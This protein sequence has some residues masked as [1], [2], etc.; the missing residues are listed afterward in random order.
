[1]ER[2]G[3]P[4]CAS[5]GIDELLRLLASA[6]DRLGAEERRELF[7]S[8]L[9]I[10]LP[11]SQ[12]IY[13]KDATPGFDS[14][15][16]STQLNGTQIERI[17]QQVDVM[18]SHMCTLL[19]SIGS[20]RDGAAVVPPSGASDALPGTLTRTDTAIITSPAA[21][22][23][24]HRPALICIARSDSDGYTPLEVVDAIQ[25]RLIDALRRLYG[26]IELVDIRENPEEC[27]RTF[28][29]GLSRFKA[30]KRKA[31]DTDAGT[32]GAR[33]DLK[34]RLLRDSGFD[35]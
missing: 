3:V 17:M 6:G 10:N 33:H 13:E 9:L 18:I 19:G 31:C 30:A 32:A 4:S 12:I 22:C 35:V 7:D 24:Y 29:M 25:A 34:M 15:M 27:S 21:S 5:R 8:I 14:N 1:L 20:P 28:F 23:C 11:H 26:G 2:C 16:A